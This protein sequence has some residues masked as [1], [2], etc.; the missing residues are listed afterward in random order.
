MAKVASYSFVLPQFF[1]KGYGFV[2]EYREKEEVSWW[3]LFLNIKN[4][5]KDQLGGI[6]GSPVVNTLWFHCRG[7]GS[8]PSGE[9]QIPQAA[10]QGKKNQPGLCL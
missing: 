3:S 1:I 10:S 4:L 2:E 9:T 6:P 8:N 7:R 5:T